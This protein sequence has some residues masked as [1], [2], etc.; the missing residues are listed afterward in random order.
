MSGNRFT[1]LFYFTLTSF[2]FRVYH[3][4][5]FS[6]KNYL[7]NYLPK[8]RKINNDAT[9]T[10]TKKINTLY[11]VNNDNIETKD[12]LSMNCDSCNIKNNNNI[13]TNQ[14]DE[15]K[16]NDMLNSVK[17]YDRHV[18]LFTPTSEWLP[19]IEDYEEFPFNII[20]SLNEIQS[21]TKIVKN[22][23]LE[24]TAVTT[25]T[26]SG[27][28][29]NINSIDDVSIKKKLK[30]KLTA[31]YEPSL[32]TIT[33]PNSSTINDNIDICKVLIYPEN[34]LVHVRKDQVDRFAALINQPT[35][36]TSNNIDTNISNHPINNNYN[37]NI[38]INLDLIKEFQYTIPTWKKL[39][40]VCIHQSRDKR[41]GRAGPQ[42]ILEL[43]KQCE[44]AQIT[45]K[46]I[47]KTLY[48]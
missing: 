30:I 8:Q 16:V 43:Q 27:N 13:E 19:S 32:S 22:N 10:N 14:N 36:L 12:I 5:R 15:L 42:V 41:C 9:S 23:V 1:G 18:I 26:T 35:I 20:K 2:I 24:E 21:R 33:T 25:T 38:D 45:G 11:L 34:L 44:L 31:L 47:Y 28:D 40:L 4:F 6:N 48:I 3:T 46:L 37:N 17:H 7:V 29:N 39:I